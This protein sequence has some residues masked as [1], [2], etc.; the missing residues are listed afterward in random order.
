MM[1]FTVSCVQFPA[2]NMDTANLMLAIVMKMLEADNNS[3]T[4]CDDCI[5]LPVLK[6]LPTTL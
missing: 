2:N 1:N 5:T 3:L 6:M 4:G